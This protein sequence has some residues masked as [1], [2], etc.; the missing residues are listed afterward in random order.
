[1]IERLLKSQNHLLLPALLIVEPAERR[2]ERN[3][4][5]ATANSVCFSW[6]GE[7][8][9]ADLE[10]LAA[11]GNG[12]ERKRAKRC[13]AF[14]AIDDIALGGSWNAIQLVFVKVNEGSGERV[15]GADGG[16][17]NGFEVS[18]MGFGSGAGLMSG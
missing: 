7:E 9:A 10:G 18:F 8:E 17:E 6:T 1:M 12:L 16:S 4:T 3:L 11:S 13:G 15:V 2:E 14:E 5:A